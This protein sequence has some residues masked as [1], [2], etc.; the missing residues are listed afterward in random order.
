MNNFMMHSFFIDEFITYLWAYLFPN[1]TLGNISMDLLYEKL[2]KYL[3]TLTKDEFNKE[4]IQLKRDIKEDMDFYLEKDPSIH[5]KEE[6]ILTNSSFKE[7]VLYRFYHLLY[8][9]HETLLAL[10]FMNEGKKI[11]AIEIHPA[12]SIGVPFFIDHGLGVVIGETSI[13]KK[14][15]QIYQGVTL[16]SKSLKE[17]SKLKG[18]K[19]HPTIED[20]V[21]IYAYAMV[22]GNIIIPKGTIIKAHQIIY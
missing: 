2:K 6:L 3:K 18:I 9:H 5:E 20:D 7:V 22:L 13:I 11:S 15:V 12:V 1:Y 4:I 8:L 10:F 21:V 14:R 19:R 17:G 16:G